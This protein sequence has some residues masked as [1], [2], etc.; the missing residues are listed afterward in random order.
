MN[1]TITPK[2]QKFIRF[3]L[4]AD[5]GPGAGFR[6]A[7]SPGGCSGL[8]SDISV[9]A[10]PAEGE[11][12]MEVAGLKLFL[13]AESRILLDGVTIDFTDGAA[14]TGLVFIT[15]TPT[16]CGSALGLTA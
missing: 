15:P 13:N 10:S 3:M 1:L 12:E 16:V 2:A 7:V 9:Q 6:L 14:K 8:N 5:G 4:M 11:V